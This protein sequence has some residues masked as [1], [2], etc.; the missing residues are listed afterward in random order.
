MEGTREQ[1]SEGQVVPISAED[2]AVRRYWNPAVVA[3][4][5]GVGGVRAGAGME[6]R[7]TA[8]L[9]PSEHK[10]LA[11]DP[12]LGDRR[13]MHFDGLLA[14]AGV[15]EGGPVE[16]L[17]VFFAD[18]EFGVAQGVGGEFAGAQVLVEGLHQQ[19]G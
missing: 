9:H 4:R 16:G 3:K 19:G 10:S 1:G 13:H 15:Y 7:A 6:T 5:M 17:G 12:G 18:V 11:G 14:D 8:E 2:G